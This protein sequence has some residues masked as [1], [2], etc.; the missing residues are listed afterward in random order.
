EFRKD[1]IETRLSEIKK[2]I[3]GSSSDITEYTLLFIDYALR[4]DYLTGCLKKLV[5]NNN[6]SEFF[7]DAVN[8]LFYSY[9]HKNYM[10]T[11]ENFKNNVNEFLVNSPKY[12]LSVGENKFR[13][14]LRYA[15]KHIDANTFSPF[16]RFYGYSSSEL[17][18][19]R[20]LKNGE[21]EA[22]Y[23]E[24][25]AKGKLDNTFTRLLIVTSWI[26]PNS[27]L[28]REDFKQLSFDEQGDLLYSATMSIALKEGFRGGIL[29]EIGGYADRLW[30]NASTV[31][32]KS[33]YHLTPEE[34]K[35]SNSFKFYAWYRVCK[36]FM[37]EEHTYGR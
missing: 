20:W 32:L 5:N 14:Y 9:N 36:E 10:S 26:D 29:K 13:E 24:S 3:K 17:K 11:P 35:L 34:G 31:F 33:Y 23:R 30:A 8:I 19:S 15:I 18:T 2:A 21:T 37:N 16:F 7:T 1:K 27:S 6:Y 28:N 25:G 4:D 12:N 22:S